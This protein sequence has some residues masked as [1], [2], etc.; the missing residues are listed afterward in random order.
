MISQGAKSKTLDPYF[1]TSPLLAAC[2]LS[3]DL[4]PKLVTPEN[5]NGC[6]SAGHTPLI[7]ILKKLHARMEYLQRTQAQRSA[8]LGAG[9]LRGADDGRAYLEPED[10]EACK[11]EDTVVALRESGADILKGI[12]TPFKPEA[13]ETGLSITKVL[14][15]T[16]VNVWDACM[17]ITRHDLATTME[18]WKKFGVELNLSAKDAMLRS[19]LHYAA[20]SGQTDALKLLLQLNACDAEAVDF[21]G[22]NALHCAAAKGHLEATTTLLASAPQLAL[23][24]DSQG[25]TPLHCW[26]FARTTTDSVC[27]TLSWEGVVRALASASEFAWDA[28]GMTQLH[29]CA[30]GGGSKKAM[31]LLIECLKNCD[32]CAVEE[33]ERKKVGFMPEPKRTKGW[34]HLVAWHKRREE[35]IAHRKKQWDRKAKAHGWLGW[36]REICS[37]LQSKAFQ[38]QPAQDARYGGRSVWE[39]ALTAK[40]KP[41]LAAL[42][43]LSGGKFP[44]PPGNASE[45]L[46]LAVVTCSAAAVAPESSLRA[47]WVTVK[48]RAE[49]W[50]LLSESL[51][52]ILEQDGDLQVMLG[53]RGILSAAVLQRKNE[54]VKVILDGGSDPN[55]VPAKEQIRPVEHAVVGGDAEVVGMLVDAGADTTRELMVDGQCHR[56]DA[57]CRNAWGVKE[58]VE[59]RVEAARALADKIK[60]QSVETKVGAVEGADKL[61]VLALATMLGSVQVVE[62]LVRTGV[63]NLKGYET[64]DGTSTSVLHILLAVAETAGQTKEKDQERWE[65]V[66]VKMVDA[67]AKDEGAPGSS[68]LELAVR[69]GW[70]EVATRLVA[71]SGSEDLVAGGVAALVEAVRQGD[72]ALVQTLFQRGVGAHW[73]RANDDGEGGQSLVELAVACGHPL[74]TSVLCVHAAGTQTEW[75]LMDVAREVLLVRAAARE[76]NAIRA[77]SISGLAPKQMARVQDWREKTEKTALS[78]VDEVIALSS[79]AGVK[80]SVAQLSELIATELRVRKALA[81]QRN[82]AVLQPLLHLVKTFCDDEEVRSRYKTSSRFS[83]NYGPPQS[84]TPATQSS[85][86]EPPSLLGDDV[87]PGSLLAQEMLHDTGVAVVAA[88]SWLSSSTSTRTNTS[89]ASD[90]SCASVTVEIAN[91]IEAQEEE[92]RLELALPLLYACATG[93]AK[94]ASESLACIDVEGLMIPTT[95]TVDD[96]PEKHGGQLSPRW[97]VAG[98]L[99]ELVGSSSKWVTGNGECVDGERMDRLTSP[100]LSI[101]GFAILHDSNAVVNVNGNSNVVEA[102]IQ[103]GVDSNIGFEYRGSLG[104]ATTVSALHMLM[105]VGESWARRT[106]WDRKRWE[107]VGVMMVDAGARDEGVSGKSTLELA[108]RGGWKEVATRLVNGGGKLVAGTEAAL[109]VAVRQGDAAMVEGLLPKPTAPMW[110]QRA[111]WSVVEAARKRPIKAVAEVLAESEALGCVQTL[112]VLANCG[113]DET[114]SARWARMAS[115]EREEAL[116]SGGGEDGRTLLMCAIQGGSTGIVQQI[117][118]HDAQGVWADAVLL[119]GRMDLRFYASGPNSKD[120]TDGDDEEVEC[121]AEMHREE[122]EGAMLVLRKGERVVS[123]LEFA[124]GYSRHED[125]AL[126]VLEAWSRRARQTPRVLTDTETRALGGLAAVRGMGQVLQTLMKARANE[127]KR[128]GLCS[129][130][131]WGCGGGIWGLVS[132]SELAAVSRN[133]SC[134]VLAAHADA[135]AEASSYRERGLASEMEIGEEAILSKSVTVQGLECQVY[136]RLLAPVQSSKSAWVGRHKQTNTHGQRILPLGEVEVEVEVV[137]ALVNAVAV[138]QHG[139]EHCW[140]WAMKEGHASVL[141]VL[142]N[143]LLATLHA[144]AESATPTPSLRIAASLEAAL[145]VAERMVIIKLDEAAVFILEQVAKEASR[146][147]FEA[148]V[149][150]DPDVFKIMRASTRERLRAL[151]MLALA[152]GCK[153]TALVLIANDSLCGMAELNDLA[154]TFPSPSLEGQQPGQMGVRCKETVLD[155]MFLAMTVRHRAW[156]EAWL[157]RGLPVH[158]HLEGVFKEWAED[159]RDDCPK[160]RQNDLNYTLSSLGLSDFKGDAS[161]IETTD[162]NGKTYWFNNLTM[163]TTWVIPAQLGVLREDSNSDGEWVNVACELSSDDEGEETTGNGRMA[164]ETEY[165]KSFRWR[166]SAS[167]VRR[168]V[169]SS[170]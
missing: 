128:E 12:R 33:V 72:A 108:V 163:Q 37:D 112:R 38:T 119:R 17:G 39:L 47:A 166:R 55:G 59:G 13:D 134:W 24:A 86:L 132:W 1:K 149:V 9:P 103:A 70:K 97:L 123:A 42:S 29:V 140:E 5:V 89:T 92:T 68:I 64:K 32:V 150:Q 43:E 62:A 31:L 135:V 84:V 95:P 21:K 51:Y 159:S 148:E 71:A 147:S 16:Y 162:S 136:K 36:K 142:S 143:R 11:L 125:M 81:K 96:E 158:Q 115:E 164:Y 79:R 10:P 121:K 94:L 54:V 160:F 90:M 69:G 28:L 152:K 46:R 124:V 91:S 98:L 7:I 75:T 120:K 126:L 44:F 157:K 130:S 34:S 74:V 60:S 154:E 102:L 151:T 111:G 20:D 144:A 139:D 80:L 53:G 116:G 106:S 48:E 19:T 161:W 40:N 155:M 30:A 146:G 122:A 109:V 8:R 65:R 169:P 133:A 22:Q 113:C 105:E 127:S 78:D 156:G 100:K 99:L 14:L 57:E 3:V 110:S 107:R 25:R 45:E 18:I 153:A 117:L 114:F 82:S 85:G 41:A 61:S 35:D 4:V 58:S 67:G 88:A 104:L 26:P 165:S 118:A 129:R 137:E 66:G 50:P 49:Q 76:V 101:L 2:H 93:N 56:C 73:E 87:Y 131:P 167:E 168:T 63:V 15:E 83:F 138:G 141:R 6:D 52:E 170:P 23:A 27:N 145:R 77:K